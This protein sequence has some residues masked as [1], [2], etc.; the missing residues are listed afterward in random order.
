MRRFEVILI[1]FPQ[2]LYLKFHGRKKNIFKISPT[3]D[4]ERNEKTNEVIYLKSARYW[5]QVQQLDI[6][7]HFFR[8][9]TFV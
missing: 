2:I 9:E 7:K 4:W 8:K 3:L 6:F 5:I 1:F